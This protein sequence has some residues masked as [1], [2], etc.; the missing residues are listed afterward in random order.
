M[1][2]ICTIFQALLVGAFLINGSLRGE[3]QTP[4]SEYLRLIRIAAEQGAAINPKIVED[5]KKTTKL[6]ELWGYDSP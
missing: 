6:S 3:A 1:R 5:W 2:K 4:K